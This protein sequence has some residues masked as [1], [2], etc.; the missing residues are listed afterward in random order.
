MRNL[1]VIIAGVVCLVVLTLG[2]GLCLAQSPLNPS[3]LLTQF[4][5][6]GVTLETATKDQM[7]EAVKRSLTVHPELVGEIV[8]IAATAQPDAAEAIVLAASGVLP[9]QIIIICQS[10]TTV[11]PDMKSNTCQ[12]AFKAAERL[13]TIPVAKPQREEPSPVKPR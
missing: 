7:I 6:E 2:Q 12:E 3:D 9:E 10:A 1:V 13:E 8:G 4:L 5:S 11:V